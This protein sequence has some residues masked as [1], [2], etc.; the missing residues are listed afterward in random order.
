MVVSNGRVSI[1]L[2][3]DRTITGTVDADGTIRNVTFRGPNFMGGSWGEGKI[4]D[5]KFV[6]TLGVQSAGS[7]GACTFRYSSEG[8]S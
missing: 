7:Y 8:V 1:P 2:S 5:G 4:A 6:V 3:G